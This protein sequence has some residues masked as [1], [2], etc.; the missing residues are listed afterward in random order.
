[1]LVIAERGMAASVESTPKPEKKSKLETASVAPTTKQQLAQ[2][3]ALRLA[4]QNQ[5]PSATIAALDLISSVRSDNAA[6][7][8][9]NT[10]RRWS[11]L[12]DAFGA[13]VSADI[14]MGLLLCFISVDLVVCAVAAFVQKPCTPQLAQPFT[15]QLETEPDLRYV[16]IELYWQQEDQWYGA[17]VLQQSGF[18]IE[19]MYDDGQAMRATSIDQRDDNHGYAYRAERATTAKELEHARKKWVGHG[20]KKVR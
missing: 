9:S 8:V 11:A 4:S 12:V 17:I 2:L 15:Q 6:T 5:M 20:R 14:D 10:S 1:M 7:C 16:H 19:G 18:V 3:A 13:L